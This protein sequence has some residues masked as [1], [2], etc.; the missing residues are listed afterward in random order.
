MFNPD[1]YGYLNPLLKVLLTFGVGLA[2]C[3]LL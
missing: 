1:S 3:A 2:I